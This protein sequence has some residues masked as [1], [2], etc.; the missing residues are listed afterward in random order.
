MS[1]R[2]VVTAGNVLFSLKIFLAA[3]LAYYIAIRFDL[4]RPFWAV[5]TVYI[6]AHPLSGAITSKSLY[7]LLGTLIGG[8]ATIVM[9]PNLVNEP[10][11]LSAAMMPG[12]RDA[13][14]SAFSIARL[15]AMCR[16][17]PDIR[18]CLR[19]CHWSR[20]RRTRSTRSS[21]ASRRLGLRS[22][23]PRSS[24][25]LFFR[26][27]SEQSSWGGSMLGLQERKRSLRQP[28][29]PSRMKPE[30]ERNDTPWRQTRQTCGHSQPTCNMTDRGTA[31]PLRW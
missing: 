10:I 1:A 14:S 8:A 3:M 7:R 9:V 4:P 23:A 25:T 31:M 21:P 13:R 30:A 11:L 28:Q 15:A 12:C 29:L 27:M 26:F 17:L 19:G 6:V 5:A 24:A 18:Y 2:P 20:R 22:C 16:F